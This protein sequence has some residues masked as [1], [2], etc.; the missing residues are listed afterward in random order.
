MDNKILKTPYVEFLGSNASEVTGSANLIRF[1][2]YHILV[3]YGLRQ[4]SNEQ[5]DYVVN[6]KRHKDIKPKK[7]DAIIL[8]H[9]HIDHCGL[10]PKLYAEGANCP[11]FIP[12]GAK[13]LLTL[14]WQDSHKIFA[15][16]HERFNRKPLYE[17]ADID[18]ALSHVVEVNL[19]SKCE[20]NDYISFTYYNAQHIVKGRQIY[21]E[22]NDG[23]NIKKLGFTGDISSYKDR[24]WLNQRDDLPMIDMLIGECTYSNSNR[25]IKERDRRTDVN[26]LKLAID[27]ALEHK[28][29]VIIPTFSL[30]RLQ[31]ILAMLYQTYGS[32]LPI[33]TIIDSPL[34]RNISQIWDKLIDKDKDLWE[35]IYHHGDIR[36]IGEFKESVA[37][38][39]IQEPL[40]VIAGGGMLSGGRAT[41]WCKQ[42]L[43]NKYNY[44]IFSGYNTPESPAGQIR[45]GKLKSVKIDGVDIRCAAHTLAFNSFS[46]HAD[47][48]HLLEY[49]TALPYNKI[50]LVHSE[51][52]S[53][54]KFAAELKEN[55]SK[56]NRSSRVVI[57]NKD[58]KVH[59]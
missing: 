22:L 42:N 24:Y 33:K 16:E 55:L 36:W 34:G 59:F 56:A 10:V 57:T 14:M 27:Y 38:N 52:D 21:M 50:C 37:F 8:T 2:N 28:S 48:K 32:K 11:L 9:C 39:Q 13:G 29:K 25:T 45:S 17:Q 51:Q 1:M 15:S 5:E 47:H 19:W 41:W 46:S 12:Q 43:A 49:Y 31:D 30:N 3:D 20:I 6:L 40:L 53:K 26:K 44:V 54:A 35:A 58:S 4:T 23:N 7:L 18:L